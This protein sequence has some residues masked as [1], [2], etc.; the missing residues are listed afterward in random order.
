MGRPRKDDSEKRR[1]VGARFNPEDLVRLEAYAAESGRSAG[2]E[3]ERRVRA[4]IA[5]DEVGVDLIEAICSEIAEIEAAYDGMK[6]HEDLVV[7]SA[8]AHMMGTGPIMLRRPERA[9]DDETVTNAYKRLSELE[10]QRRQM[11]EQAAA[12]GLAWLEEPK[13]NRP[14]KLGGD[15]G[16][17]T[18]YI[19]AVDTRK[20]ERAT[21][22]SLDAGPEKDELVKLHERVCELDDEIQQAKGKWVEYLR[23]YSD[24]EEEGRMWNRRRQMRRAIKAFRSGDVYDIH[25]LGGFDPWQLEG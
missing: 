7:W 22:E 19:P 11:I 12:H 17:L 20:V 24:A 4:T 18:G 21:I 9:S 14:G 5:L 2:A 6:W 23:T 1:L 13:P 3:V 25:Q 8:V 15:Q 10:G 16:L